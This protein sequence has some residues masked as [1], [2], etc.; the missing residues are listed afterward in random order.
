MTVEAQ[1]V[2]SASAN[3]GTHV[4]EPTASN[5]DMSITTDTLL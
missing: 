3:R 4:I 5:H 1:F 2:A